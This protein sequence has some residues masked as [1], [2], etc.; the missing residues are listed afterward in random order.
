MVIE[1]SEAGINAAF[2]AKIPVICIPDMK[3][4]GEQYKDMATY[5]VDSLRDAMK[6]IEAQYEQ[7]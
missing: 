2:S 6:I 3:Y 1:D 5:I 7:M 4:P